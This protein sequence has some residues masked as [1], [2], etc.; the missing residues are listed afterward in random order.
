M[1]VIIDF[2]IS[3]FRAT[4]DDVPPLNDLVLFGFG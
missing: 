4:V 3:R 2:I 1:V